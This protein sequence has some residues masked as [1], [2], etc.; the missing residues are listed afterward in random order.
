MEDE[1][2]P[3]NPEPGGTCRACLRPIN[4][5]AVKCAECGAFQDWRFHSGTY[6]P[7]LG[8][9]VAAI[10]IAPITVSAI[11]SVVSPPTG[12]LAILDLD[13]PRSGLEIELHNAGTAPATA[14][15]TVSCVVSGSRDFPRLFFSFPSA[16]VIPPGG[17]VRLGDVEQSSIVFLGGE[18]G[19]SYWEFSGNAGDIYDEMIAAGERLNRQV[20]REKAEF[21]CSVGV[22][23]EASGKPAKF[24]LTAGPGPGDTS[25]WLAASET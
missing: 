6:L 11:L 13:F 20:P 15:A 16:K 5:G 23:G 9:V 1:A 17:S 7:I 12:Q 4:A 8:F 14:D 24:H 19:P 22:T 25:W 18:N 2:D 10:S 21:L 3:D